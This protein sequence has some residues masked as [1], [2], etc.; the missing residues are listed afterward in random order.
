M[1]F[2]GGGLHVLFS[3][4]RSPKIETEVK[5]HVPNFKSNNVNTC[6]SKGLRV[7]RY[8]FTSYYYNFFQ[9][10]LTFLEKKKICIISAPKSFR[11]LLIEY[12]VNYEE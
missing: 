8:I 11:L 5:I 3:T 1:S 9:C 6:E 12:A 2:I 4:K 10:N 7:A